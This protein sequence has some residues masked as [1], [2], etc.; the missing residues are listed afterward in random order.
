M[1]RIAL[2]SGLRSATKV[3][4]AELVLTPR[5]SGHA[6][7]QSGCS[8]MRSLGDVGKRVNRVAALRRPIVTGIDDT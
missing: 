1:R 3:I 2:P 5:A 6:A 7:G 4:G 8:L